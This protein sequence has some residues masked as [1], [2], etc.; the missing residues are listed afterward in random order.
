MG[1]LKDRGIC[2]NTKSKSVTVFESLFPDFMT[3][4]AATPRDYVQT[5]WNAFQNNGTYD[6]SLNGKI[7]ELVIMT[8]LYREGIVPYY[9]QAHVTFVPGIDFDVIL[10]KEDAY[11][12]IPYCLSLKTSLRERWKQ[13][14][15][16]GEALKNVH[17]RAK[18]YLLCLNEPEVNAIKRKIQAGEAV[19]IDNTIYCLSDEF[20]TFIAEL[21]QA[22]YRRSI[23]VDV[24]T[25]TI[26]G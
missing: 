17:R 7:F 22:T 21:K 12:H 1:I 18:C 24:V 16:E 10:Y 6:N 5:Y 20:N 4:P 14:D 25:G 15:L 8:L 11:G 13:A 26:I 3:V 9:T 19:G 23:Q 2:S